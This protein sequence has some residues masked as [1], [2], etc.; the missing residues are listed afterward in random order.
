MG[1]LHKALCSILGI[2]HL[3]TSAYHPQT[4]GVSGTLACLPESYVEEAA[5]VSKT[6][7]DHAFC[8]PGSTP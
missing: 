3:K 2:H 4:D 1:K 7:I 6:G 8:I 5:N